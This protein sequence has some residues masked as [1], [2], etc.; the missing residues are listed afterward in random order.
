MPGQSGTTGAAM[1]NLSSGSIRFRSH[2]CDFEQVVRQGLLES[3]RFFSAAGE[4]GLELLVSVQDD[5]HGLRVDRPRRSPG[6]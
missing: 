2:E 3:R 4:P 1:Q 5:G 6:M